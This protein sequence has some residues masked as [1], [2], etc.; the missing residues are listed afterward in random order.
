MHIKDLFELNPKNII[1]KFLGD[2]K[3]PW[4]ALKFIEQFFE[5][6][7]QI[8]IYYD[9]Y[10]VLDEK[11][12]IF[13]HKT[14]KI[15]PSACLEGPNIVVGENTEIKPFAYIRENVIISNSCV[16]RAEVKNSIILDHATVPHMS[17][18]GDSILGR[19]VN[20]GAHTVLSNIKF[21][22]IYYKRKNI[23][24]FDTI[25][26][27]HC[28]QLIDTGLIKFGAILG[29]YAQTGCNITL[30]PGTIVPKEYVC[31]IYNNKVKMISIKDLLKPNHKKET[32]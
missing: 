18:I 30:K 32:T 8:Q 26:I 19:F 2:F 17:Y 12:N 31:F 4:F 3:Y 5:N 20:L 11:H 14:A 24:R 7:T 9:D 6:L 25:K 28:G 21:A 27:N 10:E 1:D 23:E 22:S 29:D 16:I 13:K 15:H